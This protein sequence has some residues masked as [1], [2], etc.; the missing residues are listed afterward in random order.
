MPTTATLRLASV[1][2]TDINPLLAVEIRS[3]NRLHTHCHEQLAHVI[4]QPNAVFHERVLAEQRHDGDEHAIGRHR[5][6]R[7]AETARA[8]QQLFVLTAQQ[9]ALQVVAARATFRRHDLVDD[10]F[11]APYK[12]AAPLDRPTEEILVFATAAKLGQEWLRE[13]TEHVA[14]TEHVAGPRLRPMQ[15]KTGLMLWPVA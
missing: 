10:R 14:P 9:G 4:E 15:T 11:V 8:E 1:V 2:F 6:E 7:L 5:N 12:M 13:H 3:T